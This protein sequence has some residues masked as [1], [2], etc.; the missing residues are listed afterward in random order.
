MAGHQGLEW[1]IVTN[2][3]ITKRIERH[4]MINTRRIRKAKKSYRKHCDVSH[5]MEVHADDDK[6]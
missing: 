1:K 5:K 6:E 4:E 3:S 2:A